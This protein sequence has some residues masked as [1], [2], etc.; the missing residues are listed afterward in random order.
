MKP[1]VVGRGAFWLLLLL[2]PLWHGWLQPSH[3]LPLP[4]VLGV[5]IL[6]LLPAA[7]AL[8]LRATTALFWAGVL[9]LPYFIHAIDRLWT[10]PETRPYA[11]VE[12]VL[13][14]AVVLAVACDGLLRRRAAK[15]AAARTDL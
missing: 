10:A 9:S 11:A 1:A 7:A 14:L 13:S 4:F 8:L 12:L 3:E 15:A 6:P 5:A 2:Q